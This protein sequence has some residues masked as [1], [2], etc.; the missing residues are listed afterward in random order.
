MIYK[1]K[2]ARLNNNKDHKCNGKSFVLCILSSFMT[3]INITH[4]C[5][6]N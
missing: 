6:H 2:I 5:N 4:M 1:K 3:E